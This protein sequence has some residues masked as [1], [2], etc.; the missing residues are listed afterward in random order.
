MGLLL[1]GQINANEAETEKLIE[2]LKREHEIRSR[3]SRPSSR[4]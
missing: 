2:Q 1:E 4:R 3:T